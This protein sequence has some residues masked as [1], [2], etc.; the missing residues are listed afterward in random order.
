[1]TP[2][3]SL[4]S[5]L[6]PL[7]AQLSNHLSE[8]E[9]Y[10]RLLAALRTVLPADAAALLR[11]EE[12]GTW[13][14]PLSIDG[15]SPDTL[16]RRFRVSE[17]PRFAALLAAGQAMRFPTDTELPDPYDG[18][19]THH[20]DAPLPVHD[21]MGCVLMVNEQ[22][23]GLLTLDALQPGSFAGDAPLA[24]LQAFSN[25]AAATVATAARMRE[26]EQTAAQERQRAEHFRRHTP[27]THTRLLGHSAAMRNLQRDI[28]TV[29]ASDLAVLITGETGVGK[30]L[31]AQAVHAQSLRADQAF[32]SINCAALP[33]NLVESELFGHV[34]GAFTG[35]VQER[36]GKFEQAHQGTLFL[37]EV[38]ELPLATQ[39]KLLRVLQSGHIQRLG[40][41]RERT[42]NVRIIA[43]TNQDLERAVRSGHMRADFF[44]RLGVFPIQVPR[45][46]D[47]DGDLL[48][49]AGHFL[50]RARSEL[51][52]DQVR[53]ETAA[54]AA[55]LDHH[56]PGNVRELE[57]CIRRSVLHAMRRPRTHQQTLGITAEDLKLPHTPPTAPRQ[58]AGQP[59]SD[60]ASA[61]P[62]AITGDSTSLNAH[63]DQFKRTLIMQ[64]LQAHNHNI[65]SSARALH[66]DR[67]N[68][69]RLS[70]RLGILTS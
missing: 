44:H 32:V 33:E 45:L 42:V 57:H 48:V 22:P 8:P 14:R 18:L 51:G 55:L 12:N 35:A 24:A 16:G 61:F 40:L 3:A 13:L 19:V 1:M 26:L 56:W 43:A 6:L 9:R 28:A 31:V 25:L 69:L 27:V 58:S 10:R 63:V 29:A 11:F 20:T 68:L 2:D 36:A 66:V 70:R 41:D 67:S 39:A 65:A 50:E 34:R 59:V 23:W 53:L 37:D 46:R 38:G 15:L 7:I 4:L 17:H 49:L 64:T 47:R 52:L 54:Q 30:E 21:C 5:A 62:D 60:A